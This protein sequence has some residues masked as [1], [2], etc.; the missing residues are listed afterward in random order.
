MIGA[1]MNTAG[2]TAPT[3]RRFWKLIRTLTKRKT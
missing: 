1:E 2:A 3:A